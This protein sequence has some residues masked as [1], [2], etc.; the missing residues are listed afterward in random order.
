P[1]APYRPAP[2][3]FEALLA[4]HCLAAG[5][6]PAWLDCLAGSPQA[7]GVA[8]HF[9]GD[10][11]AGTHIR[12][13]ADLDRRDQGRVAANKRAVADYGGV[14]V[15]AVVIAGDG[16]GTITCNYDG[17]HKHSTVIGDGAFIGS[18]STLVAPVEIGAGAYVGAGSVITEEV[19]G[20][21]LGLGR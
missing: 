12:S 8:W 6:G 4:F 15:D 20:D 11:A 2:L 13:R 5:G 3:C 9:L 16:A 18:N 19:P 21:A 10:D 7:E 14:L 1:D 17:V